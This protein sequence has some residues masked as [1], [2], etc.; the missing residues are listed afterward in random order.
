MEMELTPALMYQRVP[1]LSLC[2]FKSELTRMEQVFQFFVHTDWLGEIKGAPFKVNV[3]PGKVDAHHTIAKG[4]G[5]QGAKS[6]VKV[7]YFEFL[8]ICEDT[9]YCG[10]H[11]FL[12]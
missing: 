7:H 6:G 12:R 5:T 10:Y 1:N 2:L 3:A 8:L 11:G 9:T 4:E